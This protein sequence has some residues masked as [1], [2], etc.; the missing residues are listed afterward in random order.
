MKFQSP[1]LQIVLIQIWSKNSDLAMIFFVYFTIA[2]HST[3]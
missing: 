2:I 3:I 1:D